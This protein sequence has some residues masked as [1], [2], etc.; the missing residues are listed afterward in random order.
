ML[1]TSPVAASIVTVTDAV[2]MKTKVKVSSLR[3]LVGGGMALHS[4]IGNSTLQ[5]KTAAS[6]NN[7]SQISASNSSL[8][9]H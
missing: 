9:G 7:G 5:L 6:V 8:S 3:P 2:A 4:N 1:V